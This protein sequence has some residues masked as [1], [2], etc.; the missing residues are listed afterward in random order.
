MLA[1]PAPIAGQP[2][3]ADRQAVFAAGTETCCKTFPDNVLQLIS[4]IRA[5]TLTLRAVV[6]GELR[7]EIDDAR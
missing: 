6:A 2:S 1:A 5:D 4:T 3:V 7:R